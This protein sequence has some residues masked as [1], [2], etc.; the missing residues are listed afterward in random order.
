MNFLERAAAVVL[1]ARGAVMFAALCAMGTAAQERP[2]APDLILHNAL[3]LTVDA[4]FSRAEAVAVAGERIMAVGS[5]TR[6]C[7]RWPAPIRG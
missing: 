6:R 7:G 5:R 4:G 1:A 2:A 3:V